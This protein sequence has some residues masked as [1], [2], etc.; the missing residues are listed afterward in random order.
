ME[1]D[2]SAHLHTLGSLWGTYQQLSRS[3]HVQHEYSGFC[4]FAIAQLQFVGLGQSP[5]NGFVSSMEEVVQEVRI[6]AKYTVLKCLAS[7]EISMES[8]LKFWKTWKP[9]YFI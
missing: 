2:I 6:Q 7:Q 1:C 3:A 8:K 9:F 5:L 4:A